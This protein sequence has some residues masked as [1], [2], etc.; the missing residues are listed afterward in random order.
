MKPVQDTLTRRS[1]S[2]G[3]RRAASRVRR[4]RSTPAARAISR[5][6]SFWVSKSP[7][8]NTSSMGTTLARVLTPAEAYTARRRAE[9]AEPSSSSH[10]LTQR[11]TSSCG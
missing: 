1:I 5:Y 8:R 10:S 6:R 9:A 4:A 11:E 7:G 2:A 3:A